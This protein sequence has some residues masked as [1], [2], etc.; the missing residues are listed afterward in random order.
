MRYSLALLYAPA[1][2]F[3]GLSTTAPE[4]LLVPYMPL[5]LL[6]L[7]IQKAIDSAR[8]W[9]AL[10]QNS[11]SFGASR[12]LSFANW[13]PQATISFFFSVAMRAAAAGRTHDADGCARRRRGA[14]GGLRGGGLNH[15]FDLHAI[16]V[17]PAR[18]RGGARSPPQVMLCTTILPASRTWPSRRPRIVQRTTRRGLG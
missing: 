15:R 5:A 11:S 7:A 9:S 13:A 8:V 3:A 2:G 1:L 6:T 17:T 18:W 10:K 4:C 16:D 14:Q 12:P